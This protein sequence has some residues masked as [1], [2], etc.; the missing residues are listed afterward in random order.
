MGR[1]YCI[2]GKSASGKDTICNKIITEYPEI[3]SIILYTTRP[4]RNDEIHG[5]QYY[6][7]NMEKLLEFEKGGKVIEKRV[8]NTIY[9]EWVYATIDDGQ[10]DLK[11]RDY[12]LIG[13]IDSYKNLIEYF[14]RKN[15][16]PIYIDLDPGIRLTRALE[17]EKLQSN[18]GYAELCRR[19]LADEA[20][21]S[22]ERLEQAGIDEVYENNELEKCFKKI[23]KVLQ[24]TKYI[25][26]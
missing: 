10:I 12:I 13:T 16:I 25:D 15:V 11:D 5:K 3:K 17:R 14:G 1:I 19:F 26:E 6:F 2:M 24:S 8:Y 20:D 23:K 9:G 21:F 4:K 18:P 7:I 22:P